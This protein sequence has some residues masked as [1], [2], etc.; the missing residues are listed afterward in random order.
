MSLLAFCRAWSPGGHRATG[1]GGRS[2]RSVAC[3]LSFGLSCRRCPRRA[4]GRV[5]RFVAAVGSNCRRRW[6]VPSVVPCRCRGSV[7]FLRSVV[8]SVGR[9]TPGRC[10]SICP[11]VCLARSGWLPLPP[12]AVVRAVARLSASV[13]SL[14]TSARPIESSPTPSGCRAVHRSE[15]SP[16]YCP[17]AVGVLLPPRTV[18]RPR[19]DVTLLPLRP[20][21]RWG[22]VVHE[23]VTAGACF[24]PVGCPGVCAVRL[25]VHRRGGRCPPSGWLWS[26]LCR[27]SVV[28]SQAVNPGDRSPVGAC[29]RWQW[30][31]GRVVLVGCLSGVCPAVATATGTGF[32]RSVHTS[33]CLSGLVSRSLRHAVRVALQSV[34]HHEL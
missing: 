24:A 13:G 15:G 12:F 16:P 33:G 32:G 1:G 4:R 23:T 19:I 9:V 3:R 18:A 21:P 28:P 20:V 31:F 25:P 26:V 30:A 11:G 27:V 14:S 8:R 10:L 22:M 29:R 34:R 17:W 7:S 6:F 2:F 5:L